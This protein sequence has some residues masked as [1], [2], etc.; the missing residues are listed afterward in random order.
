MMKKFLAV[1]LAAVM[2][3]PV[4]STALA[5]G[6]DGR[7]GSLPGGSPPP[8]PPPPPRYCPWGTHAPCYALN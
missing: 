4:S 5:F 3:V 2:L 7:R 8:P 1:A 6:E